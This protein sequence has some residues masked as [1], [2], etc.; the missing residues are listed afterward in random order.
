MRKNILVLCLLL[1][2]AK[3]V[4]PQQKWDRPIQLKSCAIDIK[5]DMFT[6][7][8]FME[9][10]FYNPNNQEIE[11]LHRFELKPGQVITA[12]QLDLNGKYRDGSIEEKWKA[13][14]TYNTIGLNFSN[15]E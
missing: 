1:F 4:F 6:A 12:F 5:S 2:N 7:T 11:G 14:N 10:V 13:T 3:Q 15:I 9:M 8:T